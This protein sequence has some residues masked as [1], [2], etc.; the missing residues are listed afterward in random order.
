VN[1]SGEQLKAAELPG[2]LVALRARTDQALDINAVYTQLEH[3]H[4]NPTHHD[5]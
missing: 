5:D 1:D 3:D 4:P 2:T